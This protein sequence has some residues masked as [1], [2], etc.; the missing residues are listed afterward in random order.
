MP[1]LKNELFTAFSSWGECPQEVLDALAAQAHGVTFSKGETIIET[2]DADYS[3][4]WLK[5][6][7]WRIYYMTE[8]GREF[9]K[10]FV[11]EGM[12][13]VALNAFLQK[14]AATFNVQALEDSEAIRLP[15]QAFHQQLPSNPAL[16][17]LW[18]SYMEQ[19]FIRHE[20]RERL[21]LL[22]SGAERYRFF[23][24]EH[25]GLEKRIPQYHIASYLGLTEQSLSRI[26]AHLDH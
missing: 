17:M 24:R 2:G 15:Y 5:R 1:D 9:I 10:A 19:H 23:L 11:R 20:E 25:P 22:A 14:Q 12:F 4:Y 8:S 6:G 18:R 7:I 13:F 3:L 16:A 21:L 26:K